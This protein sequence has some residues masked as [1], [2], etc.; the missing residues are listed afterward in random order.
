MLVTPAYL[1]IVPNFTFKSDE[2][3]STNHL[4]IPPVRASYLKKNLNK[5]NTTEVLLPHLLRTC[6]VSALNFSD[7]FFVPQ[8]AQ[9]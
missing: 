5:K 1:V 9:L 6:L 4:V 7:Y 8:F 3:W 2:V